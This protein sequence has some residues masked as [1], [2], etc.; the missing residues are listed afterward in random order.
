MTAG[1]AHWVPHG[2]YSNIPYAYGAP[3]WY[4][5]YTY[6]V[7]Q[8]PS[9]PSPPLFRAPRSV[10]PDVSKYLAVDTTLLKY[11]V[12]TPPDMGINEGYY[13]Y[14]SCRHAM[15]R[16]SLSTL[17]LISKDFPWKFTIKA[18]DG[19]HVTCAEVWRAIYDGLGQDIEDSEWAIICA[20]GDKRKDEITEAAKSR[21]GEGELRLKRIDWLGKRTTFV[22]IEIDADFAQSR[23]LP[24]GDDGQETLVVKMCYR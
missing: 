13:H 15:T 20:L 1:Y 3:P 18:A 19:N 7:P 16:A 4:P 21:C 11:D 9:Y 10:F 8:T 23:C 17:H 5:T 24:G 22:G 12:R 14:L 6:Y 2:G